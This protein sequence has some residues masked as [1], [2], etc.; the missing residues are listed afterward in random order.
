MK[1]ALYGRAA[2]AAVLLAAGAAVNACDRSRQTPLGAAAVSGSAGLVRMLVVAGADVNAVNRMGRTA[3]ESAIYRGHVEAVSVLLAAGAEAEPAGHSGPHPLQYVAQLAAEQQCNSRCAGVLATILQHS[4]TTPGWAEAGLLVES[5]AAI[6]GWS[7]CPADRQAAVIR[8]LLLAA[9]AHSRGAAREGLR[10]HLPRRRAA[11][12]LL[13]DTMVTAWA[14]ASAEAARLEAAVRGLQAAVVGVAAVLR[15]QEQEQDVQLVAE[16]GLVASRR[17]AELCQTLSRNAMN[18]LPAEAG[19]CGSYV[20]SVAATFS[21][22]CSICS[23]SIINLFH[24]QT[25]PTGFRCA[26]ASA[27]AHCHSAGQIH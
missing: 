4:S 18:R 27:D 25:A 2:N 8:Q 17:P 12:Q 9:G 5:A 26:D 13:L 24:H 23:C 20:L 11:Q 15:E 14:E 16:R 1:A 10:Q 21:L 19:T 3:L 22:H 7:H 6:A